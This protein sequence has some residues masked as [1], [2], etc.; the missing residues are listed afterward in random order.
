MS[1]FQTT[2]GHLLGIFKKMANNINRTLSTHGSLKPRAENILRGLSEDQ[3]FYQAHNSKHPLTIYQTSLDRVSSAWLKIF[4]LLSKMDMEISYRQEPTVGAE[5]LAEYET[6]L[7]R[8]NEHID[9]CHEALRCLRPPVPGK[10]DTYHHQFLERSRFPGWESFKKNIHK[11][12]RDP[13]ISFMVNEIKHSSAELFLCNGMTPTAP[14]CGFYLTGAYPGGALGPNRELHKKFGNVAT[15]FS[16]NRDMMMNFWW[17][18][19]ISEAFAQCIEGVIHH[20]HGGLKLSEVK[21]SVPSPEWTKLCQECASL[22]RSFFPDELT[23][24]FPIIV[25]PAGGSSLSMK[26]QPP[27]RFGTYAPMDMKL[28][29]KLKEA[30]RSFVMPYYE[31][32]AQQK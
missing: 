14:V 2:I 4:P 17:L 3:L 1:K 6:L 21:S 20:D 29:L 11:Q 10:K 26:L 30:T 27:K 13:H 24:P 32:N 5:I 31:P 12:Y 22:K 8:L 15:A 25:V 18:Y 28:P 7:H 23:K 9:A 19:Q 16:F